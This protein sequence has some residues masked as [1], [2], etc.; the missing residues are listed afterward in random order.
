MFACCAMYLRCTVMVCTCQRNCH[1]V[2]CDGSATSINF[3][4]SDTFVSWNETSQLTSACPCVR[5]NEEC[6][7]LCDDKVIVSLG[8]R[9]SYFFFL[10]IFLFSIL[11]TSKSQRIEWTSRVHFVSRKI[12]TPILLMELCRSEKEKL[13]AYGSWKSGKRTHTEYHTVAKPS[14][15]YTSHMHMHGEEI[16]G[17]HFTFILSSFLIVK[18]MPCA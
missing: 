15:I 18:A 4:D 9:L 10:F 8:S 13:N 16:V 12:P 7:N 14:H 3:T 17:S 6:E 5:V 1:F 2:E 11:N